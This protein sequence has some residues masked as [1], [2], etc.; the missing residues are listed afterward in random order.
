MD[1]YQRNNPI[2]HIKRHTMDFELLPFET[3]VIILYPN[4]GFLHCF[5]SIGFDS[6]LLFKSFLTFFLICDIKLFHNKYFS[7]VPRISGEDW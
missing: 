6:L 7:T 3:Q 2:A 5:R 4:C 1:P